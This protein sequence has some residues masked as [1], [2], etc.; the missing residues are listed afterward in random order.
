VLLLLAAAGLLRP[1]AWLLSGIYWLWCACWPTHPT[2]NLTRLRYLGLVAIAPAL[3][4]GVDAVV[5]GHPLYSLHSTSGLAAELGR[6]QSF[7]EVLSSTWSYAVRI[8]KL[9]VVLGSIAGGLISIWLA[10]RRSLVPLV[11]LASLLFVFIAEGAAGASVVDRYM[12][13]SAVVMLV[14]CALSVDGRCSSPAPRCG[15]RGWRRRRSW[16]PTEES[17]P[18]R[19]SAFRACARRSPTT[20]TSIRG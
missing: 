3:W 14:L 18:R 15:G 17:R 13:G 7:S 19:R 16:W 11:L 10:P 8:D 1:D 9:P 5:T 12:I 20:R 6:T 4:L 2:S